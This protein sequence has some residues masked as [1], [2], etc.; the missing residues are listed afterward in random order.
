MFKP[1]YTR[2]IQMWQASVVIVLLLNLIY[3]WVYG[4][5]STNAVIAYVV[6]FLLTTT[7]CLY[8][9]GLY[10]LFPIKDE[11]TILYVT[12][13]DIVGQDKDMGN[14]GSHMTFY[15]LAVLLYRFDKLPAV[16]FPDV[17]KMIG[18]LCQAEDEFSGNQDEDAENKAKYQEILQRQAEKELAKAKQASQKAKAQE[19]SENKDNKNLNVTEE[20]NST[21]KSI[22]NTEVKADAE[23]TEHDEKDKKAS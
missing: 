19:Q 21:E 17:Y 2:L 6:F 5:Y 13:L 9:I 10:S 4:V 8:S 3:F 20:P 18:Q 16:K 15:G 23:T 11:Q 1:Y 22:T 14:I 12:L 7:L